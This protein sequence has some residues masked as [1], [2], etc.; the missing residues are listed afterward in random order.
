MLIAT[1]FGLGRLIAGPTAGLLAA[2][3]LA[4]SLRILLLA[5][6]IIIDVHIT[7]FLGLV[8]LFFALAETRPQRRRLYLCLMY[9]A[10][11]L[12]VLMK[13]PV[14]VFIPTIVFLVYLASEKRLGSIRRMML[15][16]GA[17]ISLAIMP[18]FIF[19]IA[20]TASVSGRSS[21]AEPP[22]R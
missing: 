3:V 22:I 4:T 13:G 14:A 16:T 9:A 11:G 18:W 1:A 15:P 19:C 17:V 5:R 6:R 10:A 12:G 21:L 20:T 7:M 2:L 8:L